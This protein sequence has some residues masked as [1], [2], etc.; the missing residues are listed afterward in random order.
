MLLSFFFADAP[1]GEKGY[2][3]Q[4]LAATVEEFGYA[5]SSATASGELRRTTCVRAGIRTA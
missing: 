4:N 5:N 2:G 3:R 1:E